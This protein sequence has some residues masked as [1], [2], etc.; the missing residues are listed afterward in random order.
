MTKK[1]MIYYCNKVWTQYMLGSE[2]LWPLNVSLNYYT[3]LQLEVFCKRAG[4][5]GEVP[6]V[7]AFM[8]FYQEEKKSEGSHLMVQQSERKPKRGP[9]Q[10]SLNK[11]QEI[12]Q[13]PNEDSSEFLERIYQAYRR[14]TDADPEAPENVRMV[15]MTFIRQSASDI[16]RTL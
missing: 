11:I 4:K 9:R 8:L 14:Y 1:D 7:E 13:K 3:I 12:K 16:R 15:N 5:R 2:E 6:Y 10:K